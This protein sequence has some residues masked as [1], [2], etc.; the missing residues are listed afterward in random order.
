LAVIVIGATSI[1][2][3]GGQFAVALL[4]LVVGLLA[5]PVSSG[6]WL[7]VSRRGH[8]TVQLSWS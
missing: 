2:L 4:P 8:H 3:V 7:E 1:T 5:A 6:R